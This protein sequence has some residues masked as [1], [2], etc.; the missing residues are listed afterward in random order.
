MQK[1]NLLAIETSGL[2][3]SVALLESGDL[4][5][6]RQL[7]PKRRSATTLAPAIQELLAEAGWAPRDLQFVAVAV[8]PGSF[9]GL[10]V[11][12]TAAKTLA[13]AVGCEVIAVGTLDAIAAQVPPPIDRVWAVLDAQRQQVFAAEFQRDSAG[14]L[15]P[16]SGPAIIDND[17]WLASLEPGDWVTGPA[18]GKLATRLPAGVN[19][20]E[21]NQ[22]EPR[23]ATVGQLGW[24][25][26]SAGQRD[27]LWRLVPRYYRRSAAEEKLDA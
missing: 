22:W 13:Y 12:V 27:D 3:G 11:G 17:A 15:V 8:G 9:T 6:Q 1:T 7:D 19:V 18:L 26:Y 14:E 23:A 21:L 20:V 2:A 16:Q 4:V 5:A 25:R 10:R 24:R